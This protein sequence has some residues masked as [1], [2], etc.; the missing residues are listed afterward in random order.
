SFA[1]LVGARWLIGAV[2]AVALALS[3]LSSRDWIEAHRISA[4][5]VDS[6]AALAP[7]GG[8]LI[9]LSAP[10]NYRTAHIFPGGEIDAA[11]AWSGRADTT[12]SICSE[13]VVR[14]AKARSLSFRR[15]DASHYRGQTTWSAPFDFPVSRPPSPLSPDCSYIRGASGPPGLG[16]VAVVAPKPSKQ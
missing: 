3:L 11:L 13:V 14:D 4:R 6:A 12:T 7:P 9:L 10:E 8:E 16:L 1:A 5:V 2:V 15:L